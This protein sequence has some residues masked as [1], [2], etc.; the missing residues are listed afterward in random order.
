MCRRTVDLDFV[1]HFELHVVLGDKRCNLRIRLRLLVAKLVA[2][3]P[4]DVQPSLAVRVVFFVELLELGIVF[5]RQS[6]E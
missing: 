4:N 6:S 5:R 1:H 3:K 2:G